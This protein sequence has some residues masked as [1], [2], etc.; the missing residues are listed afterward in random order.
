MIVDVKSSQMGEKGG[1]GL[2]RQVRVLGLILHY[3]I[4]KYVS[5]KY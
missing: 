3:I 5:A 1:G 2:L 4:E